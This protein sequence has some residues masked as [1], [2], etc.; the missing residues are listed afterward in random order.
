[1]RPCGRL[2]NLLLL[3]ALSLVAI[4]V[5]AGPATGTYPGANGRIVFAKN[6][7]NE[8][9]SVLPDG[10]GLELLTTVAAPPG[11]SSFVSFPS[12]SADGS[13]LAVMLTEQ[14]R[15]T[16]CD[17]KAFNAGSGRCGAL[18]LMNA[19]GS[20]QRVVYASED[21]ASLDLALSPDGS[22]I[23]FTKVIAKGNGSLSEHLFTIEA[24]G[25]HLRLLTPQGPHEPATDTAP[26]WSPDGTMIA[27]QSS[28]DEALTGNSWSLFSVDVRTRKIGR[29][30]PTSMDNDVQP[31]WSPDG[32]KLVFLRTF[33]YPDYRIY[34]V[35]RDGSGEQEI[36]SDFTAV[37]GPVWSP[38]GSEILYQ[39]LGGLWLVNADGSNSHQLVSAATLG[40]SWEPLP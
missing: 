9:W 34:S 3:A 24:D 26:T 14:N 7:T 36:L 23:V 16:P 4:A 20:N 29:I 13:K 11:V 31:N 32:S 38:D 18:V 37:Q 2:R 35:N 25:K 28:R 8:L 27:F 30:I 1:M 39:G 15:P 6:A 12:F 5:S 40:Y 22:K 17:P 21:V 10:T 33:G 19:D